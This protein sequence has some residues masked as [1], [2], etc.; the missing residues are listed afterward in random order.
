MFPH[1]F[2]ALSAGG[3]LGKSDRIMLVFTLLIQL[4]FTRNSVKAR[5]MEG[6]TG[7]T[8]IFEGCVNKSN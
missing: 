7:N 8:G 1:H 2:E 3:L 5:K 6:E 4:L